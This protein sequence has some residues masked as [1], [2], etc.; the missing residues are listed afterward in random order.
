MN[1]STAFRVLSISLI[2]VFLF[3]VTSVQAFGY[4]TSQTI[5]FSKQHF[6][7]VVQKYNTTD[8]IDVTKDVE[9]SRVTETNGGVTRDYSRFVTPYR[10]NSGYSKLFVFDLYGLSMY[11]DTDYTFSFPFYENFFTYVDFFVQVYFKSTT[12][13]SVQRFEVV[14]LQRVYLDDKTNVFTGTLHTPSMS[15][16]YEVN[17]TVMLSS[18]G[19][20][21]VA[22]Q[23]F[24]FGDCTFE[25]DSPLYGDHY[26]NDTSE[27]DDLN[28]K[29]TS[30]ES[31]LPTMDDVDLGG[32]L[33][34]AD[35]AKYDNGFI[36]VNNMF[37]DLVS[38]FEI[39]PV[40]LFC[41][42]IGLCTY[43]LGRRLSN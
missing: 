36:A 19:G 29:I 11:T 31:N 24:M 42:A 27:I 38:A 1:K 30:V 32:L 2:A 28:D 34:D 22:A 6:S 37:G 12:D 4:E 26:E 8:T 10:Y 17:M 20:Q 23:R 16:A 14:N 40:I 41:L 7:C 9:V 43:L 33:G 3:L 39:G 18:D 13:G 35:I 5:D 21:S 15:G 25:I